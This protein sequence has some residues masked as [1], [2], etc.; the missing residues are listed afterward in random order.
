MRGI[1]AG[2]RSRDGGSTKLETRKKRSVRTTSYAGGVQCCP[3]SPALQSLPDGTPVAGRGSDPRPGLIGGP[4]RADVLRRRAKKALCQL[5]IARA[6]T[7]AQ[8]ESFQRGD[9][10]A[11]AVGRVQA[12]QCIPDHQQTRGEPGHLVIA[13]PDC[14]GVVIRDGFTE[15]LGMA[16]P[17]GDRRGK[18]LFGQRQ[19]RGEIRWRVAG[20]GGL[21]DRQH[22]GVVLARKQQAAGFAATRVEHHQPLGDGSLKDAQLL[23]R[24]AVPGQRP[25]LGRPFVTQALQKRRGACRPAHGV[26]HQIGVQRRG[27]TVVA[28]DDSHAVDD[29]RGGD[30]FGHVVPVQE[31]H[32]GQRLDPPAQVKLH[33]RPARH[34][35]RQR[36]RIGELARVFQLV[37]PE[38]HVEMRQITVIDDD[39]PGPGQVL[40]QPGKQFPQYLQAT[41]VEVVHMASLRDAPA[42][43]RVVGQPVPLDHAHRIVELRKYSRGKQ[44]RH[45]GTQYH[46]VLAEPV[47]RVNAVHCRTHAPARYTKIKKTKRTLRSH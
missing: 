34:V 16:Q 12:A 2:S 17:L 15:G 24:I 10:H 45:S 41:A 8:G 21:A 14:G 44:T 25:V 4:R 18:R 31:G 29:V 20:V 13:S 1:S 5:S 19:D 28:P 39:R 42:M 26:H 35:H 22:P 7:V 47:R 23:A 40:E 11:L 46:C 27:K 43:T 3:G 30:E 36:G 9:R 32:I 37:A 33:K 38:A 6:Q